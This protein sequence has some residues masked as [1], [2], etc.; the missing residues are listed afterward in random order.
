MVKRK[1]SQSSR[2]CS[3][4]SD[5]AVKQDAVEGLRYRHARGSELLQEFPVGAEPGDPWPARPQ[6]HTG[7]LFDARAIEQGITLQ[8]LHLRR[9]FAFL[10]TIRELERLCR[11]EKPPSWSAVKWLLRVNAREERLELERKAAEKGWTVDELKAELRRRK[12]STH[13]G[14]RPQKL[15][16]TLTAGLEATADAVDR[17]EVL[18]DH[19]MTGDRA[20]ARKQ[21]PQ[22]QDAKRRRQDLLSAAKA[23]VEA[24]IELRKRIDRQ[25]SS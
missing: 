14:G 24:L 23:T 15:P 16:R 12:K 20:L 4:T 5:P 25:R 7:G 2:R 9:R 21:R 3:A 6:Y 22:S 13:A 8:E 1:K 10:Y 11:Y 18:L 19:L 17:L